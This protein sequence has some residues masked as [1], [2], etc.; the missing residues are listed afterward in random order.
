[1]HTVT[2]DF[3]THTDSRLYPNVL[4]L[5]GLLERLKHTILVRIRVLRRAHD[6][7][8]RASAPQPDVFHPGKVVLVDDIFHH[9]TRCQLLGSKDH[10]HVAAVVAKGRQHHL[11]HVALVHQVA[12]KHVDLFHGLATVIAR[13][14]LHHKD[15]TTVKCTRAVARDPRDHRGSHNH[16]HTQPQASQHTSFMFV[17]KSE[18]VAVLERDKEDRGERLGFLAEFDAHAREVQTKAQV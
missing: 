3:R 5:K 7:L 10:K 9:N 14:G 18:P 12:R 2:H 17:I 11:A 1:M 4:A 8:A 6:G 16:Q 15:K 13:A